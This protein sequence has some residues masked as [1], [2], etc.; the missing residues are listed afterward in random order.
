MVVGQCRQESIEHQIEAN[1]RKPCRCVGSCQRA[2]QAVR[3][4]LWVS[5]VCLPSLSCLFVV[6]SLS[7]KNKP[8]TS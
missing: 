4:Q 1:A 2:L 6:C 3:C 8:K 7:T 5:P